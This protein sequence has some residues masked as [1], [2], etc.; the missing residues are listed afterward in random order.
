MAYAGGIVAHIPHQETGS[1]PAPGAL[2]L[3]QAV[4]NTID[5]ESGRDAWSDPAALGA[6]LSDHGFVLGGPL[7]GDDRDRA[8]A[9]REALRALLVTNNGGAPS[10]EA[11]ETLDRLTGRGR[12]RPSVSGN[13]DVALV[14]AEP[15]LDGVF[16]TLLALVH[17]AQ[18][19]GT[20]SRLKACRS[21]SCRWAFFD[22]AKNRSG[23]WC[24][25]DVCG[26]REK[27]RAYRR[28][29]KDE[30]PPRA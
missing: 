16:A 26:S 4:V 6:W 19:D 9:F 20:W 3:V 30:T 27:S 11:A 29:L 28:R 24:T 2:A 1:K 5:L 12:L 17:D 21:E 18:L 7:N 13:G 23:T 10:P 25:M 14:A 15:G 22:H 8:I